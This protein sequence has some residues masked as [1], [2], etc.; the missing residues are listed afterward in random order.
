M[1]LRGFDAYEITL[2]DEMRGERASL[3]KSLEDVEN[4]LRIKAVVITAIEDCDVAR[5]PNQSVI[6][7][8]VRSYARYL[9]LD[10]NRC[11]TQFCEEAGFQSQTAITASGGKKKKSAPDPLTAPIGAE[12]SASRFA[13]PPTAP[14]MNL[15]ISLGTVFS[16]FALI[17]TLGG[18]GYGGFSVLQDIQRVDFAPEIEAPDIVAEAP[19]IVS[20]TT[21]QSFRAPAASD[22]EGQGALAGQRR[23]EVQANFSLAR[24]DGPIS[25][26]DPQNYGVFAE[27]EP[28]PTIALPAPFIDSADDA[29]K[30]EAARATPELEPELPEV[31]IDNGIAVHATQEAWIRIVDDPDVVLFQGILGPG[32]SFEVPESVASPTIRAGNAGGV[33][34]KVNGIAYGPIGEPGRVI[35]GLPL[36]A[37]AIRARFPEADAETVEQTAAPSREQTAAANLE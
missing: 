31:E 23:P 36:K 20:P 25:A 26:I 2:G 14:R 4:D 24:R 18:L 22:Y 6:P 5:F 10:P 21:D 3:G 1:T 29:I 33:Y 9:K 15:S 11:Y 35:K 8:Y 13:A 17:A 28:L 34:I 7:G 12:I 19:E 32:Q 37:E 16:S 27:P 30:A